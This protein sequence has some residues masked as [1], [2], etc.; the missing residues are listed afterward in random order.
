MGGRGSRTV[1]KRRS[2]REDEVPAS[3]SLERRADRLRG[4]ARLMRL[5]CIAAAARAAVLSRRAASGRRPERL[6]AVL[7]RLGA[8]SGVE[9]DA[10]GIDGDGDERPL[11]GGGR[12]TF[13][14]RHPIRAGVLERRAPVGALG[15]WCARE[16]LVDE[17]PCVGEVL[18]G[19]SSGGEELREL[20]GRR[21]VAQDATRCGCAR[22]TGPQAGPQ[23]PREREN[24]AMCRAFGVPLRGFEPRFPP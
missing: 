8:P 22:A 23:R 19:T 2:C 3:P 20:L 12:S 11:S 13:P 17:L 18:A 24:P 1:T 7:T 14:G 16:R 21:H 15:T 10:L 9:R 5:V 6:V 4:D